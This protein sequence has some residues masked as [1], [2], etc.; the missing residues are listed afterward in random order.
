M[1]VIALNLE[2]SYNK[3]EQERSVLGVNEGHGPAQTL[4]CSQT[5]N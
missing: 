4:H 5:R 1:T 2:K 3:K